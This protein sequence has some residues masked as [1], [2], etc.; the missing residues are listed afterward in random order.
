MYKLFGIPLDELNHEEI[1]GVFQRCS[2]RWSQCVDTHTVIF[3]R[4][5]KPWLRVEIFNEFRIG[6]KNAITLLPLVLGEE[7]PDR[8]AAALHQFWARNIRSFWLDFLSNPRYGDNRFDVLSLRAQREGSFRI[9][10]IPDQN[11]LYVQTN[12][13]LHH[14]GNVCVDVY[15]SSGDVVPKIWT[16]YVREIMSDDEGRKLLSIYLGH[17]DHTDFSSAPTRIRLRDP[18]FLESLNAQDLSHV[19][20][21]L[22]HCTKGQCEIRKHKDVLEFLCKR[23]QA[24]FIR[25]IEEERVPGESVETTHLRK[26]LPRVVKLMQEE[27]PDLFREWDASV[28]RSWEAM[29]SVRFPVEPVGG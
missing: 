25:L 21:L 2:V 10:L 16:T 13:L 19:Q 26:L 18:S 29:S 28:S 9:Q 8:M 7:A 6:P 22:K 14:E 11:D 4:G 3:N 20:V 12:G 27:E 23:R 15:A 1:K 24:L 17:E 5:T